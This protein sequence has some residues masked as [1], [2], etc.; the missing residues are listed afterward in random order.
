MKTITGNYSREKVPQE[1][2]MEERKMEKYDDISKSRSE[3]QIIWKADPTCTMEKVTKA[4]KKTFEQKAAND[5]LT[6]VQ[7]LDDF[8]DADKLIELYIKA[9]NTTEIQ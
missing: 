1:N 2:K 7:N 9:S 3:E 6:L 5:I 4:T 8:E